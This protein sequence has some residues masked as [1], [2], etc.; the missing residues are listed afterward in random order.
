MK[1]FG[2]ASDSTEDA[3]V[4]ANLADSLLAGG[5][6]LQTASPAAIDLPLLVEIARAMIA[7]IRET[8]TPADEARQ[9]LHSGLAVFWND[10]QLRDDHCR[11][12]LQHIG[13]RALDRI[14][15]VLPKPATIRIS[16]K[17]DF[18]NQRFCERV[19]LSFPLKPCARYTVYPFNVV[20][21]GRFVSVGSLKS[22]GSVALCVGIRCGAI[23]IDMKLSFQAARSIG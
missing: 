2:A 19:A 11:F 17:Y 3:L 15:H 7:R 8:L 20:A 21:H 13:K 22:A 9:T 1:I 14:D 6:V 23:S 5:L 10:T 18:D 16:I 12:L 4:F